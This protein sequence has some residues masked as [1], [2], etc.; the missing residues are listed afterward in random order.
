MAEL[1][2]KIVNYKKGDFQSYLVLHESCSGQ[3]IT[4][5]KFTRVFMMGRA[6]TIQSNV[7]R[8]MKKDELIE[9]LK[10]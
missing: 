10:K 1:A 3:K 5:D 9:L 7:V 4:V 6:K 2:K 8:V